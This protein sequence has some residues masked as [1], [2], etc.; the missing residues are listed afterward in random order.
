[1]TNIILASSSIYR[2]QLLRQIKINPI[3][4]KPEIDESSLPNEKPMQLSQRLAQ[5]K[6]LKVQSIDYLNDIVIG[7]DQVIALE[8][9]ILGKPNNYEN[10][11]QQLQLMCGKTCIV[12]TAICMLYQQQQ[13]K[14]VLKTIVKM[15]NYSDKLIE[16]YLNAEKP[17]DCAG[18][19]KSE[20]LGAILIKSMQSKDP[21]AL[22][23]LP[24]TKVIEGLIKF[25][26]PI[27]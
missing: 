18:S 6:A 19:I 24:L 10:A 7:S 17:F 5:A 3:V 13:F 14:A 4:I 23:G 9:A 15:R 1:M 27:L 12:F 16:N 11:K 20:G 2:L 26:Y 21:T 25:N 22:I 8:S